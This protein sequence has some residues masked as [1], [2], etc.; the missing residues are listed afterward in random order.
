MCRAA[1]LFEGALEQQGLKCGI[2]LLA[3]PLQQHR[4]AKLDGILQAAHVVR[5][6][7][8]EHLQLAAPLHV[9]DPLIGLPLHSSHSTLLE[10]VSLFDNLKGP[11]YACVRRETSQQL[12]LTGMSLLVLNMEVTR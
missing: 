4:V 7:Q 2:Q 6:S 1:C 11:Y 9:L 3:H 8:L 10:E 5:L 12:M